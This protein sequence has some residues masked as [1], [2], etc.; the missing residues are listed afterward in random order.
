MKQA[1]QGHNTIAALKIHAKIA[2]D[3]VLSPYLKGKDG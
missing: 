2:V 1:L 3:L